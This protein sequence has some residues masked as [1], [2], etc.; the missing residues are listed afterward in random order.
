LF[1]NPHLTN[2]LIFFDIKN[3]LKYSNYILL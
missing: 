2:F 1:S 3:I